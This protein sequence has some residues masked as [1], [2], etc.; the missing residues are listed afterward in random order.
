M[1]KVYK[2]KVSA[3]PKTLWR[4]IEILDNHTLG[5]FDQLIR[6]TFNYDRHDHLSMFYKGALSDSINFGFIEP[7]G[8]GK[9]AKETIN[10]LDIYIGDHLKYIYDFGAT[11]IMNV[12]LLEIK[13]IEL[14]VHYPRIESR[15]KKRNKYCD[16]CKQQGRKTI[17]RQI[18][19]YD[20]GFLQEYLCDVCVNDVPEDTVIEEILD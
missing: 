4:I 16:N 18:A 7:D 10:K 17:A 8:S 11:S 6:E 19:F 12:E 9:G 1:N 3:N 20:E 5:Q 14:N 13:E 15:N 2:F